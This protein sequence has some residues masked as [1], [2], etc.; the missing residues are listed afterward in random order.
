MACVVAGVGVVLAVHLMAF[1]ALATGRPLVRPPPVA[2]LCAVIAAGLHGLARCA[3]G[4]SVGRATTTAG[5]AIPASPERFPLEC[6]GSERKKPLS[7]GR[8]SDRSRRR[9]WEASPLPRTWIVP[10]IT[11]AGLYAVFILNALTG[12]PTGFDALHYHM[13]LAVHWARAGSLDMV[14]GLVHQSL[15]GNGVLGV[16]L[17]AGV[18]PERLLSLF[19]LPNAVV[20]AMAVYALAR[21]TGS[22]YRGATAAACIAL[23]IP[24][25]AYQ[26]VSYYVDLPGTTSAVVALLAL[27]Q[28]SRARTRASALILLIVC[29]LAAGMAIGTKP[30]SILFAALLVPLSLL[31]AMR[32][33][34][35]LVRWPPRCM[36]AAVLVLGM[37]VPSA[38]WFAR[39]AVHT[40]NPLYPM[41]VAVGSTVLLDGFAPADHYPDRSFTRRVRGWWDYPWREGKDA[42]YP[43]GVDNGLGAAYATFVPVGMALLGGTAVRSRRWIGAVVT[44]RVVVVVLSVLGSVLLVTVYREIL[45][46]ALPFVLVSVVAAGPLVDRLWRWNG[47][48]TAAMLSVAV[49]VPAGISALAPTAAMLGRVRDGAWTRSCF[50]EVPAMVDALPPGSRI[51]NLGSAALTYPLMGAGGRNEV[52]TEA[53]WRVLRGGT[54][55]WGP[56]PHPGHGSA[57]S[58]AGGR[59][60]DGAPRAVSETA[61]AIPGAVGVT[62][63]PAGEFVTVEALRRAGIDFVHVQEPLDGSWR[64][65]PLLPPVADNRATRMAP[66]TALRT[67]YRVPSREELADS[68]RAVVHIQ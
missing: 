24:I 22:T 7:G 56:L 37:L 40:G 23:S 67:L 31:P 4:L 30:T 21:M 52:I 43:Y 62:T 9:A 35:S 57:T 3:A 66:T 5:L 60:S 28:V 49:M 33:G 64:L 61:P 15:P 16:M 48:I 53:Q 6:G 47:R 25:V 8:G 45:R 14:G 10:V 11:L 50:Y 65:D 63:S 2:L 12:F 1:A 44:R 59:G 19:R 58:R 26:S 17:G 68:R 18:V 32:P 55:S 27:F 54:R 34:R 51:L 29:G 20:L 38:F 41:R 42:G 46:F 13:P 39:N 36:T